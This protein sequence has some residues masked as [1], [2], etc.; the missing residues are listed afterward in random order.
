[1]IAGNTHRAIHFE[2]AVAIHDGIF[3]DVHPDGV[4]IVMFFKIPD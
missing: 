2:N 1:M 4:F 3:S